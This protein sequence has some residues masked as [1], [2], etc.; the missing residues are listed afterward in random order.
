PASPAAGTSTPAR[1]SGIQDGDVKPYVISQEIGKGSFATVYKG[2]HQDTHE[3]VAIKAVSRAILTAKLLENLK[4]EI[5]ILKKLSYTHIT[6]LQEIV[7]SPTHIH[8]IMEYC[9]GGDLSQYIKKRGRVDG[10]QYS[11]GPGEP[12]QYYPHP[13]G[14]GLE[15][16]CVRCFLRQLGRALKFIRDQNLIHRDIKPQN[17]LLTPSGP[18]DHAKGHPIGIPVLKVADF[19]FARILPNA[20]LAETLCGS[21]LYMAPEILRYEKYDAKADLWSV[22][23]VLY[24]MSVGKPPFRAQNHIEL[25]RKIESSK[26]IKFP[27]EDESHPAHPMNPMN[28]KSPYYHKMAQVVAPDMKAL[29]RRLLVRNPVERAS[30]EEF[31]KSEALRNSKFTK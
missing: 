14:G 11:P 25:L 16:R 28:P 1:A 19:G 22:G 9:A 12:L 31:F 23:A 30:F 3:A 10:L 8:L 29:M 24:E 5:D 26:G 27:E 13:R 2:Y 15:E 21:P 6:K 7:H 20:M 18:L 17:L 4:S